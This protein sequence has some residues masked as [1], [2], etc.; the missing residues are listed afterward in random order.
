MNLSIVIDSY[1]ELMGVFSYLSTYYQRLM[2]LHFKSKK[3]YCSNILYKNAF[4]YFEEYTQSSAVKLFEQFTSVWMFPLPVFLRMGK[5]PEDSVIDNDII[6]RYGDEVLLKEIVSASKV[7]Y[8]ETCFERYLDENK[9]IYQK[10]LREIKDTISDR[11][12]IL[13]PQCI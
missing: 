11:D 10:M 6:T 5:Y 1:I 12:Y 7:F 4:T 3:S 9:E 13:V 2:P 8:K